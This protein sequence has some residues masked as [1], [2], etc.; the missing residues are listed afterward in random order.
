MEKENSKCG[1]REPRIGIEK[2]PDD[3][4]IEIFIRVEASEW[5]EISCV[6]KHWASLFHTECFWQAALSHIFADPP[7]QTWLGPIPLPAAGLAKR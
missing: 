5:V 6:K 4:L 3:V 7:P 1:N 2:L